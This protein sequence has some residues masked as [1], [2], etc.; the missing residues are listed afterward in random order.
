MILAKKCLSVPECNNPI[1]LSMT[2]CSI[3]ESCTQCAMD[4]DDEYDA[5]STNAK[6]VLQHDQRLQ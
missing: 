2:T 1:D 5:P 4:K 6:R 3:C